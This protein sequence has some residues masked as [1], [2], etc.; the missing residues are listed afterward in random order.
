MRVGVL[1]N[2]FGNTDYLVLAAERLLGPL[3]AEKIFFLGGAYRDLDDLFDFKKKLA[4]GTEEYRDEHFLADVTDFLAGAAGVDAEDDLGDYKKK[5]M[6][7]PEPGCSEYAGDDV[8]TKQLEMIGSNIVLLVHTAADIVKDDLINSNI[9][10]HA[11]SPHGVIQKGKHYFVAPGHLRDKEYEGQPATF[12][13]F[14]L[15]N[16]TARVTFHGISGDV[17]SES[18]LNI[19]KAG[20]IM[21]QG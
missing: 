19:T 18:R 7:V 1:A 13:L 5:F 2:T 12:A 11:G 10:F 20:K 9:I 17:L 8:P 4:R 21:V 16:K 14:E 15:D 6:R 3:R